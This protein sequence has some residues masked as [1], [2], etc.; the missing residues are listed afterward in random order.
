MIC[1]IGKSILSH[2]EIA[3]ILGDTTT[4]FAY[5]ALIVSHAEICNDCAEFLLV[6]TGTEVRTVE[7]PIDQIDNQIDNQIDDHK[8]KG[9]EDGKTQ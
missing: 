3:E 8:V 9:H 4:S 1:T 2:F 5:A 7:A 6:P